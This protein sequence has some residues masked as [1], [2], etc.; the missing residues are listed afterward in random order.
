[1]LTIGKSSNTYLS[2]LVQA[3]SADE[4]E[5]IRPQAV[6]LNADDD[7]ATGRVDGPPIRIAPAHPGHASAHIVAAQKDSVWV[8][9]ITQK[10]VSRLDAAH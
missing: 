8:S 5:R 3:R 2:W 7:A 10:T 1:M 9:S 4:I 6:A